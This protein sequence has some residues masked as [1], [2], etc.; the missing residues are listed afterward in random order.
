MTRK[1]K[2]LI[3]LII[4]GCIA[5]LVFGLPLFIPDRDTANKKAMLRL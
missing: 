5:F 2:V 4:C 1:R 3:A